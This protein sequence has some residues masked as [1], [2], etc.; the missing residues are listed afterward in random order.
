[1]SGQSRSEKSVI[2]LLISNLPQW[3][4]TATL[5]VF[6]VSVLFLAGVVGLAIT[7]GG[8]VYIADLKFGMPPAEA[9]P[10]DGKTENPSE[11]GGLPE[12]IIVM[13]GGECSKLGKDW[14]LYEKI[15]GRFPIGAGQ[16]TDA[17]G[18]TKTFSVGQEDNEGE[19]THQLTIAEMP[20]HSHGHNGGY[21]GRHRCGGD[22]DGVQGAAGAVE[23][24]GNAAHNNIP[25]Y[26]VLNFCEKMAPA[27]QP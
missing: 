22:C 25:P 4:I 1:M 11:A 17:S 15:Q 8:V 3:S 14:Q 10:S 19:Y 21:S 2:A 16:N 26:L 12:H 13:T 9:A 5:I 7:K 18:N 24:G 27:D 20:R 6:V 23:A